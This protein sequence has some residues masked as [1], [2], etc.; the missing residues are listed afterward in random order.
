MNIRKYLLAGAIATV[1]AI[2]VPA[3]AA[4]ILFELSGSR[5]AIFYD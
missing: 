4:P 3:A 1:G 2:A 5:A